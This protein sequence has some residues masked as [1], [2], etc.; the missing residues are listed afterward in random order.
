MD[1]VEP[2]VEGREVLPAYVPQDT[3]SVVV[4]ALFQGNIKNDDSDEV[5]ELEGADK[6]SHALIENLHAWDTIIEL[7]KRI[8]A[9]LLIP[10][11]NQRLFF[12][13]KKLDSYWTL[14]QSSIP[15][16]AVIDVQDTSLNTV[17]DF[18]GY[19]ST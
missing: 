9:A 4:V 13:G 15:A 8:A 19:T 11:D 2:Q 12:R 16:G 7:Q 6:P 18:Y 1:V 14:S 3:I 5:F 17:I 10:S